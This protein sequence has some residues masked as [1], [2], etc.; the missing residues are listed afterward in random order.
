MEKKM[1]VLG[2]GPKLIII[3]ICYS[4]V[5]I[6]LN[7]F[8]HD[9]FAIKIIP[10]WIIRIISIVLL[11]IGLPLWIISGKT[12]LKAYKMDVLYTKGVFSI[13]RHPLYTAVILFV[14]P[15]ALL[16][17]HSWIIL[18]TPYVMIVVCSFIVRQEDKYLGERFPNDFPD[19]RKRV[20]AFLPW[21]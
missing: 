18:S 17:T 2:V 19:Y 10:V 13:C 8:Y 15:G 11:G 6:V 20:N 9:V 21:F 1:S 5:A 12:L 4:I 16:F 3:G 7:R 14:M